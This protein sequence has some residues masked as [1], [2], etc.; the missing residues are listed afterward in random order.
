MERLNFSIKIKA[1]REKVWKVLWDDKTYRLWT[2]VFVEGSYAETDWKEGGKALFLTP[3]GDGMYSKIVRNK[4]NEF[5]S[6]KHLGVVKNF[7]ELPRDEETLKWSGSMEN[8]R[9]TETDGETE[10]LLEIDASKEHQNYFKET[11][12]KALEKV[13]EISESQKTN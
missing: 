4:K 8:Y 13:K 7:K 11:F 9:L 1:T 5:M 10:L 12:P 3:A 2:S 6:F